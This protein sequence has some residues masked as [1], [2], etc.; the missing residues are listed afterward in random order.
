MSARPALR[1]GDTGFAA[2]EADFTAYL[3]A[4]RQADLRASSIAQGRRIAG[5]LLD[6]VAVTRRAAGM[7]AGDNDPPMQFLHLDDLASAVEH[8]RRGRLSGAF[9]VAPD[10]W[11]PG[12]RLTL[13]TRFDD[14]YAVG[15][16]TSVGTPKAGV[17]AEG[18]ATVVAAQ[19]IARVRGEA[20]SSSYDG[21]G[22]CYLEFGGG[23]VLRQ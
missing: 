3:S 14:V 11:I 20:S 17:F 22:V 5:S 9:N 8:V 21:R 1:G 4:R 13:R 7:R 6:E 19:L 10:G 15:D 18:Q 2:F 23:E 16:V 12:D